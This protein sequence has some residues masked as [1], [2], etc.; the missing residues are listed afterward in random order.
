MG[1]REPPLCKCSCP[2]SLGDGEQG[3]VRAKRA[4]PKLGWSPATLRE[5]WL[6]IPSHGRD[7]GLVMV[8]LLTPCGRLG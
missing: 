3:V 6:A 8:S 4:E 2:L 1:T 7:A 5:A